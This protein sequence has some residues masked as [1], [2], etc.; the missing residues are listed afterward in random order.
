M[1]CFGN[2]QAH[3]TAQIKSKT[4]LSAIAFSDKMSH[5][6][7][8]TNHTQ[9]T[10]YLWALLKVFY[11]DML[12]WK[13][14]KRQKWEDDEKI[15]LLLKTERKSRRGELWPCAAMRGD[16]SNTM[17]NMGFSLSIRGEKNNKKNFIQ[18]HEMT[19]L[20]AI[21]SLGLCLMA[22]IINSQHSPDV[23]E[24][25]VLFTS[26]CGK[27]HRWERAPVKLRKCT[28]RGLNVSVYV[29]AWHEGIFITT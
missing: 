3:N 1:R 10:N 16:W 8:Q 19:S 17:I 14:W 11:A 6:C 7:T 20:M 12:S 13:I 18:W 23:Q 4:L 26:D 2:R 27:Q 25:L 5:P 29:S 15:L 28:R 24:Q 22:F 21:M 9:H